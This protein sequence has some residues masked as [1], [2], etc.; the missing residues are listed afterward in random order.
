[1]IFILRDFSIFNFFLL[2][3]FSFSGSWVTDHSSIEDE[4]GKGPQVVSVPLLALCISLGGC[5]GSQGK[6]RL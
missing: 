2:K 3:M 1:M 6:S 4:N 5:V